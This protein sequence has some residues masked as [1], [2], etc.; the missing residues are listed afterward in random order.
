VAGASAVLAVAGFVVA[1]HV[2]VV[3]FALMALGGLG[4]IEAVVIGFGLISPGRRD[5]PHR[6]R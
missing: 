3:G 2:A 5:G 4:A 1:Q 6:R